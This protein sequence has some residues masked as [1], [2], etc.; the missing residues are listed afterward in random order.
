MDVDGY[1]GIALRVD[2]MKLLM[3]V[4]NLTW[5]KPP[6]LSPGYQQMDQVLCLCILQTVLCSYVYQCI[7]YRHKT[8][9]PTPIYNVQV[10]TSG[11]SLQYYTLF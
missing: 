4:P 5:Y 8:D 7:Y 6:E 1:D 2:D 3:N 10:I 9:P 11:S